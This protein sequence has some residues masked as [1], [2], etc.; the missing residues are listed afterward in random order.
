MM[1]HDDVI[2]WKHFPRNWRFV[3]RIHRSTVNSRHKGQWRGALIFFSL[4]LYKRLSKQSW[5]W[6][7]ETPSHSLWCQCNGRNGHAINSLAPGRCGYLQL[8]IFI[9][10]IYTLYILSI[11]C[12]IALRWVPQDLTDDQSTL[13]SVMAWGLQATPHYL[14]NAGHFI[15]RHMASRSQWVNDNG[16]SIIT[17]RKNIISKEAFFQH[18]FIGFANSLT[19]GML[20][21]VLEYSLELIFTYKHD[22]DITLCVWFSKHLVIAT[23]RI[24]C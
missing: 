20:H 23:L 14:H 3:R 8:V 17:S 1:D 4:R 10:R 15:W 2:K 11:S 24:F 5:G 22:Y 12:K 9:S 19:S 18:S 16:A 13:V 7:F 6:W 21:F